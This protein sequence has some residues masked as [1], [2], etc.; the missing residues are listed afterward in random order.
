MLIII[1][2]INDIERSNA[3]QGRL[4]SVEPCSKGLYNLSAIHFP[5]P[6][7]I[8]VEVFNVI[9]CFQTQDKEF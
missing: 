6:G 3:L 2:W 9:K 7:L 1:M 5:L 8:D 4:V